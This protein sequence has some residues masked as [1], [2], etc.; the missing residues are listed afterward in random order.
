V[1]DAGGRTVTG[2]TVTIDGAGW[3]RAIMTDDGGQYGF[4]GLCQGTVTLQAFLPSDQASPVA[5]VTL[6]GKDAVWLDLGLGGSGAAPTA[7]N[8]AGTATPQPAST[9]EAEMPVTGFS[10]W[11]LAGGAALGALLLISAGAR[12]ALLVREKAHG[13][14]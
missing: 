5:S 4:A 12:R 6:N 11:L 8:T 9:P 1:L 14:E 7:T 13:E 10:G 2:A 3:S